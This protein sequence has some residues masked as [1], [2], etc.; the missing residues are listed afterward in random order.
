MSHSSTTDAID[1]PLTFLNVNPYS[2]DGQPP[3]GAPDWIWE[4]DHPY[5]HGIFAPVADELSATDLLVESGEIPSD[6]DGMYVV[7]GPCQR[8]KPKTKYHYY[9]GDGMLHAIY[10]KDRKA[11]YRSKW[12]RTH[13]F[14]AEEAKG[15][16]IW[17]GLCGPFDFSLPHSPI[18]DNSNTDIIHYAGK[19]LSLWYLAGTPYSIDPHTLETKGPESFGGKLQHNLSAHSRVD[20]RTGELLFFNY[21]NKEPYM[22]YGVANAEGE[23]LMDIPIDIPGPRSPHDLGI[24]PN[25]SVLHDLPYFQDAEILRKHGKRVVTFHKDIPARFGVIPRHGESSEIQWFEAEPCYVL[26]VINCWEE[27]DEVVM[28]GCRQP[29]PG[30]PRDPNDGP[31]A[32]Q[33]AERRRL[34]QLHEWRFNLK[35]GNT[36]EKILDDMNT[37]FPAMNQLFVGHRSRYTYTQLIPL[38]T[39]DSGIKGRCQTFD[40]LI[41][42]DLNDGSFQRF[43]YGDGVCGSESHFAPRKGADF[44]SQEDDGYVVTFAHDSKD[45]TS[46]CLIF[47]ARDIS[48]G[49]ITVI[50]MP[51]RFNVGFHAT[52]VRGEDLA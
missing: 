49:P 31:L 29:N 45:W 40:A 7:N 13:E 26:H 39:E 34:H 25:Y 44:D 5:L 42:Y 17:P 27:G 3:S 36:S 35:T 51:R 47:D 23:L 2:A 16:N 48:Q 46:R 52:W 9:D 10:F 21:Q 4:V 38:P 24:T 50:R 19:F 32:S 33:L 1:L 22:S 37:E 11:D 43:D 20:V 30:P 14:L 18:K 8:Y 12:I 15:E 41:K 6:L 28:L